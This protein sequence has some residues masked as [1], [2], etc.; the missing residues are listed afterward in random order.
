ML[1]RTVVAAL[2]A[3]SRAGLVR[4]ELGRQA[5]LD[6]LLH[7]VQLLDLDI[8]VPAQGLDDVEHQL[9]GCR[10]AGGEPHGPHAA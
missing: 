7:A 9:F 10:G 6:G 2:R 5:E 8:A 3:P 4:P 1:Y